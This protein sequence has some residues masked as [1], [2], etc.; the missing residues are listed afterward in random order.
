MNPN[1]TNISTSNHNKIQVNKSTN[2][3][4]RKVNINKKQQIDETQPIQY[5]NEKYSNI[6]NTFHMKTKIFQ[7]AE[8]KKIVIKRRIEWTENNVIKN[9]Y[10]LQE[11]NFD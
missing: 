11:F 7:N 8:T 10:E 4:F 2:N 1:G 3:K 9:R 5:Y 6:N